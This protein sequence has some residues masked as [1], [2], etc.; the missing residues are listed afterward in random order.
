[1]VKNTPCNAGDMGS[2]VPY[3]TGSS[4]GVLSHSEEGQVTCGKVPFAGEHQ[5]STQERP[6]ANMQQENKT[7]SPTAGMS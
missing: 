2:N 4:W 6:P 5:A 1:M 3:G 7:L